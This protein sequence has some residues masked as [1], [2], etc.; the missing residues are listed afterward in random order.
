MRKIDRKSYKSLLEILHP[1]YQEL[2][3]VQVFSGLNITLEFYF[4]K[5]QVSY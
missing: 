4:L 2:D 5:F 1:D 3:I